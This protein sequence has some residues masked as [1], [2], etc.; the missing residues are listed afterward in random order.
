M[1]GLGHVMEDIC[2]GCEWKGFIN[3]GAAIPETG[4]NRSQE[5]GYV[6]SWRLER[7]PAAPV[8]NRA[9]SGYI[10]KVAASQSG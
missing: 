5:E 3:W 1:G 7:S 10:S 9:E 6:Q 2:G 4:S 8:A